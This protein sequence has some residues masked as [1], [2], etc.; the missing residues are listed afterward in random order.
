VPPIRN[1]NP[2]KDT[3]RAL[4]AG[5]ED[6]I[7]YYLHA[8]DAIGRRH[9]VKI[10]FIVPPVYETDRHDSI[11]NQIF[12]RALILAPDIAIID[13]RSWHGDATLFYD[14][15]HPSPKY[16]HLLVE[17]LHRRGFLP[18]PGSAARA[19]APASLAQ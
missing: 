1:E 9:G 8:I 13:T 6:K 14:Y 2:L 7:A 19:A 18:E 3:E 12:D 16:Y 15:N 10:V 11:V 5:D 17:E 4:N